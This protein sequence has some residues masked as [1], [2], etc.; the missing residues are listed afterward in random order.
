MP[1]IYLCWV[2]KKLF[3]NF[4]SLVGGWKIGSFF[5]QLRLLPPSLPKSSINARFPLEKVFR[6]QTSSNVKYF[7]YIC[8]DNYSSNML[9]VCVENMWQILINFPFMCRSSGNFCREVLDTLGRR[10]WGAACVYCSCGSTTNGKNNFTVNY[11][12]IKAKV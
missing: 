8:F 7:N 2:P 12:L 5:D 6:S 9:G 4:V 11:M 3:V 1:I 10:F